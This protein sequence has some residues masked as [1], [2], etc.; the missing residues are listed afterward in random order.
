[1]I[2]LIETDWE[3]VQKVLR[4]DSNAFSQIVSRYKGA[5]YSLCYRMTNHQ[6]DA[7]DLSQEVFIKAYQHLNKYNPQYK[8][9]TWILRIA[10]NTTI[11]FQRKKKVETYPLETTMTNQEETASA[12][13]IFFHKENQGAIEKAI[14]GLPPDYRAIILLYHYYGLSYQELTVALGLPL[15]KVKNRLHRSRNLLKEQL[16]SIKEEGN[17]W[18]AR[19]LQI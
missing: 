10:T 3:I 15:S 17:P 7:E 9:S 14:Q 2:G 19:Q 12:E 16:K 18:T 4:G 8:F 5:V 6:G 11:D 13:A 1:M